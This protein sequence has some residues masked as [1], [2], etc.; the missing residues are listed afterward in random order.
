MGRKELIFCLAV[1]LTISS[2]VPVGAQNSGDR[3][4]VIVDQDA[5]G[6]C[7]TDMQSVL[8]FVQSPAFEGGKA[9]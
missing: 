3:I 7:S 5:R 4:K 2:S 8:M 6:P 1:L 9:P